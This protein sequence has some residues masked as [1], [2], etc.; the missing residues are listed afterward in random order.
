MSGHYSLNMIKAPILKRTLVSGFSPVVAREVG[1]SNLLEV[2]ARGSLLQLFVNHS[3]VGQV[4]D[5]T[6]TQGY[7]GVCV[8]TYDDP[9]AG[10]TLADFRD[11][12]VW[13][14]T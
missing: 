13:S 5:S 8:G 14:L 4:Q 12:K 3:L 10:N 2:V 1:H 9:S 7:L 11:A 6:Y